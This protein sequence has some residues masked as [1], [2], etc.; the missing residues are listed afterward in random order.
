MRVPGD[1]GGVWV[2]ETITDRYRARWTVDAWV[3]VRRGRAVVGEIRV[4]PASGDERKPG[5]AWGGR[6]G[7][8]PHRGLQRV[9]LKEVPVGKYGPTVSGLVR[10]AA[11]LPS[12]EADLYRALW[13]FTMP[14]AE[15]LASRPRP[16]RNTGRDDA[17][18]ARLADEFINRLAAGSMSPVKDIAAR[19]GETQ[20]RVRDWLHEARER[21][22]LSRAHPGKREGTLLPR[23]ITLLAGGP[24]PK[25]R[26]RR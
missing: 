10:R 15:A 6:A 17:F 21:H 20:A 22:L 5:V 25:R 1:R 9:L 3:V 2:S 16:R 11:V 4:F 18:Y 13:D 23:A 12:G 24:P 7:E 19:R 26:T 8:V 14:G